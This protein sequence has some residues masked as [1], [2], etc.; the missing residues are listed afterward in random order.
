MIGQSLI[1][2]K[3]GGR[4]RLSGI[5]AASALLLFILFLAPLIEQIPMA[6]LV[7]V[8]FMVVIFV[9]IVFFIMD[10]FFIVVMIFIMT[11]ISFSCRSNNWT[12]KL[13]IFFHTD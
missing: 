5:T 1:N 2:V 3:A 8:M 6:A 7:G 10:V 4:G 11:M 12:R 9:M 13:F